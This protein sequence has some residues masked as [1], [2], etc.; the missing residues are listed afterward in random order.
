MSNSAE[1]TVDVF[2]DSSVVE[3][4][5]SVFPGAIGGL[6]YSGPMTVRIHFSVEGSP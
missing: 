2:V 1:R 5:A 6:G 3:Q 4:D